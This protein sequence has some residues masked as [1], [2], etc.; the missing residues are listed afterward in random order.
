VSWREVLASALL[1]GGCLLQGLAVLGLL[2]MRNAHDRLHY[3]GPTSYGALLLGLAVLAR[4][5]FSLLG[6]K[7][8]L[9]AGMLVLTGPVLAHTTLRSLLV[10]ERGDWR[11]AVEPRDQA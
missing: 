2:V 8:L 3:L 4:A 9:V 7:A 10:G 11:E 6:D 5:G 1:A